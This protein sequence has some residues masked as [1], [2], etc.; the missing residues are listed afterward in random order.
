MV[1]VLLTTE[2]VT[3]LGGPA[4]VNLELDFGPRGPRGSNIFS[5]V[6][7]PDDFFT[8]EVIETLNLQIYDIYVRIDPDSSDYGAFFQYLFVDNINQWVELAQIFGPQGPTGPTG[9]R[10]LASTVTGPTGAASTVT[11]PTGPTGPTGANGSLI[12]DIS[13]S[14]P[15]GPTA[16]QVWYE[17]GEGKLYFYYNDEDS[18]QWVEVASTIG[19]TGPAGNATSYTPAEETDWVVVPTTIAEALDELAFR[20]S[21]LDQS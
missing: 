8:E 2:N 17:S 18:S 5:G 21:A 6:P 7:S 10:G 19:P 16:G 14:S 11:G 9:P 15:T 12:M 3:V 20:I 1:D 13:E 4:N